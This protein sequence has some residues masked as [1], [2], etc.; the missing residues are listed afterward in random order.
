MLTHVN[1]GYIFFLFLTNF[2]GEQI[3]LHVMKITSEKL[4]IICGKMPAARWVKMKN[5]GLWLLSKFLLANV[6]RALAQSLHRH[7]RNQL[8]QNQHLLL[9]KQQLLKA[10]NF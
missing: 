3:C 7:R 1:F 4:R 10:N 5:S 9:K 8:L 6:Q 2:F